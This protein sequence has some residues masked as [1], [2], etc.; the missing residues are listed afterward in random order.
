MDLV[1]Q[2]DLRGAQKGPAEVVEV[3]LPDQSLNLPLLFSR[4]HSP[5]QNF[6]DLGILYFL[7][8]LGIPQPLILPSQVLDLDIFLKGT[9]LWWSYNR[10]KLAIWYPDDRLSEG[11]S[12]QCMP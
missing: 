6:D 12:I 8:S 11:T 2:R 9:R 3:S 5:S 1:L 7:V 4:H 10:K